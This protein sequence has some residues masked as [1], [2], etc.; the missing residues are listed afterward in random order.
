L[1]PSLSEQIRQSS[2]DKESEMGLEIELRAIRSG[3]DRKTCWVHPRAGAIPGSPPI[4]VLTMYKLRLTGMDV[5]YPINEMR[6]DDGGKT[7]T[8]PTEHAD[9]LG[10]R[11]VEGGL[12]EGVCDWWP[13]WHEKTGKL[14]GIGHTVRYLND[15]I[16]DRVERRSTAYSVYDP[17]A[18]TW[19][20][21][22]KLEMPREG[23]FFNDGAGSVQR[24]DLPNGDILLPTY[25]VVP[26]TH[27]AAPD[28]KTLVHKGPWM[29]C[30]SAV[31]RCTFDG[32]ALHYVE[33][34]DEFTVPTGRGLCEPSLA[35][36]R[37][38]FYLT[39]RNDDYGSVASGTDGLHFGEP[40]EWTFD[41]GA[42][43]GNYNTQQHWVTM[44][45]AL[46]LVYTRRG[47]NN[48]HVFRHRA[49]LFIAQVDPDR[50]RVIR[51]TERI[52][53]P[54][55]GA[56]LCNFGVTRISENE[57]WVTVAEWMQTNPPNHHDCTVCE[58][59]GSDNSVYVARIRSGR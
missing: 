48:D 8:G 28:E 45:D 56:R 33:Q 30:A 37:N 49:P 26:G 55:R 42:D 12:E 25:F 6:T 10:R 47:A 14:L 32:A 50:L 38:R 20:P 18:R 35:F 39:L 15:N 54:E 16:P 2:G 34:G 4:V 9:T 53:V 44:P 7:W 19:A 1:K 41:D 21:W 52:L 27:L 22:K 40:K 11:K 24:V 46:Y 58:R 36:F 3:Y 5:F 23:K 17:A 13:A 59:Y 51:K 43:L 29:Q 57:S 31:L